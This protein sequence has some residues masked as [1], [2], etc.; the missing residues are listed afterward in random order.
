MSFHRLWAIIRKEFRHIFRDRRLLF[1][2]TLSPAVML[3]AFAY[4]FSFDST[5]VGLAVLDRDHSPESRAL[6]QA[7][8]TD[9]DLILTG[10]VDRYDDLRTEMQAGKIKVGLVIPPGFGAKL[11]AGR[12]V[13]VQVLGDGSDP[14]NSSSQM[15]RLSSRMA[16]WDRPYRRVQISIPVEVRTLV[17]YN[18]FLKSSNS[19]VPALLSIVLI[20]PGMAVAL[21]VTREKELGSFESLATTP[22]RASEYVLGKLIP[23]LTFGL[24]GAGVAVLV[25]LVWFRVPFRGNFPTLTLL[26]GIY[27]LATLGL[28]MLFSSFMST[29]S[30]ALRAI[31]LLFLVPSFFLSGLLLPIDPASRL[32]SD[33]LPATH[34]VAISRAVFLKGLG[35]RPLGMETFLLLAAGTVAVALTMVFFRKRVA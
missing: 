33:G 35:L 20:L 9:S 17:W 10:E 23:Y 22:V 2:V 32:V 12:Q 25:A 13:E 16:A 7:I 6:I 31:M 3:F 30:T 28:S 21:A 19:M 29:Q 4:L 26:I 15:A 8:A 34:F 1:L 24:V 14:I 11:V 27:L 5:A 18:P